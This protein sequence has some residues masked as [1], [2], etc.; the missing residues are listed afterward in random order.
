[1]SKIVSVKNTKLLSAT[2]TTTLKGAFI[3]NK[4]ASGVDQ[5]NLQL[6]TRK[7]IAEDI[8][9]HDNYKNSN[10]GLGVGSVDFNPSL[11]SIEFAK[12]TQDKE[13][14]VRATIGKGSITTNSDTSHINRDIVKTK[15]LTKDESSDIELYA[16][17][18]SINALT[19][20]VQ[21]YK[22]M[23]QKAKDV[24]LASHKEIAEDLPSARKSKRVDKSKQGGK[25]ELKK[26]VNDFMVPSKKVW[27]NLH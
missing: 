1:M 11:N 19:H 23:K 13:Q 18:S 5:G 26:E 12:S 22:D 4:D 3:T 24:G 7:L 14:I 21:T 10:V 2:A 27:V 8:Q 9:D 15:Q 6:T 17:D 25:T 16:S 20:P